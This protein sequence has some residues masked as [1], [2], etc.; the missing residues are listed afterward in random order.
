VSFFR[1]ACFLRCAQTAFSVCGEQ[2][3]RGCPERRPQ[4]NQILNEELA[5][6]AKYFNAVA[7]LD[8][9]RRRKQEAGGQQERGD[10]PQ[11]PHE[12]SPRSNGSQC[13]QQCD[14]EFGNADEIGDPL[15]AKDEIHPGHERAVGDEWLY[16]S[17]SAG[18]NFRIPIRSKI[19]TNP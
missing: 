5:G 7:K 2:G 18:V 9:A 14:K 16:A 19:T 6:T 8:R 17:A 4:E 3:I 1:T 13:Q 12:R 11:A 10:G 15:F